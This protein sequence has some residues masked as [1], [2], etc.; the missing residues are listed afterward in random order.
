MTIGIVVHGGAGRFLEGEF[1]LAQ[2]AC[3]TAATL[4]RDLLR[5]GASAL[6][7]VEAAVRSLESDPILNA[8][9][10]STV[11]SAGEVEMDALIQDGDTQRFGAVAGVQRVPHPVSLARLVMQETKHHFLIGKAAE[12][13]GAANGVSLVEPSAMLTERQRRNLTGD[14]ADTVG[15]V[16][17]DAAGRVAVA[18]STGGVRGKMP[19]RVGDTPIA[20]AGGYAESGVGGASATG[21]GEGIMR[22]LLTFRAVEMM[23]SHAAQAAAT[24]AIRLFTD[25]FDGLGGIILLD[26]QGRVGIAHNTD[27]MPCAWLD[28]DEV[29]AQI[30]Q[31]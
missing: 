13:F 20:G 11:T 25:R 5:Q 30:T 2:A 17:L 28:G 14:T 15:A 8:G 29:R 27:H 1:P 10:G 7:A 21:L 9:Y 19:G 18:V 24:E 23:R 26:Q 4:A 16:A 3:L 12:D 31:R 22:S 6:D